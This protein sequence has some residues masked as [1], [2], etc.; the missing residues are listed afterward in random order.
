MKPYSSLEYSLA[1][2]CL[3]LRCFTTQSAS[4]LV[5]GNPSKSSINLKGLSFDVQPIEGNLTRIFG[6]GLSVEVERTDIRTSFG[7]YSFAFAGIE[8]RKNEAKWQQQWFEERM[9]LKKNDVSLLQVTASDRLKR[10]DW[11]FHGNGFFSDITL[12]AGLGDRRVPGTESKD[13]PI[14]GVA[15]ALMG[16]CQAERRALGRDETVC[17]RPDYYNSQ[18]SLIQLIEYISKTQLTVVGHQA[19]VLQKLMKYSGGGAG[20]GM[21]GV[22]AQQFYTV[23]NQ[24]QSTVQRVTSL[25]ETVEGFGRQTRDTSA[26]LEALVTSW[27]DSQRQLDDKLRQHSASIES[28]GD[29]LYREKIES[30]TKDVTR[31]N[32]DVTGMAKEWKEVSEEVTSGLPKKM[33]SLCSNLLDTSL[34][35]YNETQRRQREQE[36][37]AQTLFMH[38]LVHRLSD[39]V[40]R[41]VTALSEEVKEAV[42]QS[43]ALTDVALPALNTS[44][45]SLHNL[46]KEVYHAD[47][48]AR[49][50]QLGQ[51]LTADIQ[52]T[53]KK[54]LLTSDAVDL[55]LNESVLT[56]RRS[57]TEMTE[58]TDRTIVQLRQ[59]MSRFQDYLYNTTLADL[60]QNITRLWREEKDLTSG[61]INNIS[62]A[63]ANSNSIFAKAIHDVN[64]SAVGRLADFIGGDYSA[65][66]NTTSRLLANL[67]QR[68]N[69]S[70][71]EVSKKVNSDLHHLKEEQGSALALAQGEWQTA[72]DRRT[73]L[74]NH[75]L[76]SF[77]QEAL[78]I[79]ESHFDQISSLNLSISNTASSLTQRL[80][81]HASHV[82]DTLDKAEKTWQGQVTALNHSLAASQAAQSAHLTQ[83]LQTLTLSIEQ[84][85]ATTTQHLDTRDSL[86][87][88]KHE[89]LNHSL[90]SSFQ[91]LERVTSETLAQA[92]AS[93]AQQQVQLTSQVTSLNQSLLSMQQ[94]FQDSLQASVSRSLEKSEQAMETQRHLLTQAMTHEREMRETVVAQLGVASKQ[95]QE[96][97]AS[98]YNVLTTQQLPALQTMMSE[99]AEKLTVTQQQLSLQSQS[100]HLSLNKSDELGLSLRATTEEVRGLSQRLSEVEV[101]T[102]GEEEALR[103]DVVRLQ[104]ELAED[105]RPALATV[106]SSLLALQ[107]N[108]SAVSARYEVL[109]ERLHLLQGSVVEEQRKRIEAVELSIQQTR[110]RQDQRL[111]DF[112]VGQYAADVRQLNKDRDATSQEVKEVSLALSQ[113]RKQ[114]DEELQ[115]LKEEV[116]REV[117]QATQRQSALEQRVLTL[118][119]ESRVS[120]RL[121]DLFTQ[122]QSTEE[123]RSTDV[124]EA[125]N[126]VLNKQQQRLYD[127]IARQEA[128]IQS[129]T[130]ENR[131]LRHSFVSRQD[132]DDLARRMDAMQH[133]LL[134]HVIRLLPTTTQQQPQH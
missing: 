19:E 37:Q 2:L 67:D 55:R 54:A 13:K 126:D 56:W 130:D 103:R 75:S 97:H 60:V 51:G 46:V 105:T 91:Q 73:N 53:E 74:L 84:H 98:R 88:E 92:N 78:E 123:R 66:R 71:D 76:N 118:E 23:S 89:R 132:Y 21:G 95:W 81:S 12:E 9:E 106:Q 26:Q 28:L 40:D 7:T 114:S 72:L 59:D 42:R 15:K 82:T 109:G 133:Q 62:I 125:V 18:Y 107:G 68:L 65:D 131:Q 77:Q 58:Q 101:R 38:S 129:L 10:F 11:A 85:A 111:S 113:A 8:F 39:E 49:I 80:E 87:Q 32:T 22:T 115:R 25:A 119:Q 108:V 121:L 14:T 100:L 29:R 83:Q 34:S 63:I 70:L 117:Q 50:G 31:L 69:Q 57:L 61:L 47:I 16:F 41:N 24:S 5:G 6:K 128:L 94:T 116:V 48:I 20:E 3:L 90:V 102:S 4:L 35:H 96:E 104:R 45:L 99:Q 43:R 110:E 120:Q 79:L 134:Q 127:V 1:I 93:L 52:A 124:S 27:K 64:Q 36:V 122:K 86:L 30:L 44:L 17:Q 33:T 112:I